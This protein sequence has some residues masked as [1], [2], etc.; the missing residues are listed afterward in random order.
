[1]KPRYRQVGH[2]H[3]VANHP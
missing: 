1:M 2:W 3:I